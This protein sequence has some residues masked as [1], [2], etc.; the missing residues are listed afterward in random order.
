MPDSGWMRICRYVCLHPDCLPVFGREMHECQRP[1][2]WSL[3]RTGGDADADTEIAC[4]LDCSTHWRVRYRCQGARVLVPSG[5]GFEYT[6]VYE[7]IGEVSANR[8]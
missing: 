7:T 4:C 6:K 8:G 2:D 1:A 3:M 5:Q